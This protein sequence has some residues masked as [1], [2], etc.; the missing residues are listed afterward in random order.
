MQKGGCYQHS[1]RFCESVYSPGEN[2]FSS[3]SKI[4]TAFAF[5]GKQDY[6]M[7]KEKVAQLFYDINEKALRII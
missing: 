3:P 7:S 5:S 1:A 4:T 6:A 2:S